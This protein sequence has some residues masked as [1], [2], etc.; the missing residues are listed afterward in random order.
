VESCV[1][2]HRAAS[3]EADER[4]AG[5]GGQVDRE[6]GRRGHRGQGRDARPQRLLG[7]LERRPAADLQDATA[8]REPVLP[9]RPS[10]DLVDRVV[11]VDVLAQA[12]QLPIAGEQPRCLGGRLPAF[13]R[14]TRRRSVT[15]PIAEFLSALREQEA[16]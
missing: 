14:R 2:V 15:R 11:P 1:D 16:E 10:D 7:Q 3:D 13:T 5:L 6:R 9:Q 8:Q 12:Q 4:H